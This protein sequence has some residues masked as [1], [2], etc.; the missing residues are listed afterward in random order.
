MTVTQTRAASETSDTDRRYVAYFADY[1][2]KLE[3][4]WSDSQL[5]IGSAIIARSAPDRLAR[6]FEDR[7]YAYAQLDS[8]A[9]RFAAWGLSQGLRAGDTIALVMRNRP[10]KGE[11]RI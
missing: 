1:R 7:Q 2:G 8:G 6:L 3:E 4:Y 5:T 9:D 10:E 11:A